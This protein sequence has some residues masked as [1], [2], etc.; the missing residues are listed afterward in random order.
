MV[1]ERKKK[2][3]GDE[4][5]EL[6]E[7]QINAYDF[8]HNGWELSE[9]NIKELQEDLDRKLTAEERRVVEELKELVKTINKAGKRYWKLMEKLDPF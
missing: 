4:L 1:K 9:P 6:L 5:Q 7:D 8:D 3:R 2:R